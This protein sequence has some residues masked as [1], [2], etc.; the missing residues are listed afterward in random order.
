MAWP[1]ALGYAAV[2]VYASLYPFHGWRAQGIAPW[3]FLS[4][5]WPT[6]W[7]G[8]D[9]F[10]NLLGYAPLGLLLTLAVARSGGRGGSA[11]LVGTLAPAVLSLL[12]ESAQAYLVQ[13][14]PSQVDWLLN[15]AGAILG[16]V[17]ALLLLR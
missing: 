2:V 8:F 6:Y 12:L 3:S 16:A 15:T 17:L 14:V 10:A 13:R 1:L 9:V 7:T 5:P 11:W 4:A